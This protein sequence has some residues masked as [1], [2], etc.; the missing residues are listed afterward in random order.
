MVS[1]LSAALRGIFGRKL[2]AGNAG[3]SAGGK[4]D[5]AADGGSDPLSLLKEG[6]ESAGQEGE[7]GSPIEK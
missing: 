7:P 2:Q 6:G 5:G 4:P 1:F 3:E